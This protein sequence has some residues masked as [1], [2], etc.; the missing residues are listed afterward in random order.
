[1]SETKT[2]KL[3]KKHYCRPALFI[4]ET[5][6]LEFTKGKLPNHFHIERYIWVDTL[7]PEYRIAIPEDVSQWEDDETSWRDLKGG[8]Q[9][10]FV[11]YIPTGKTIYDN[12]LPPSKAIVF[13]YE[14]DVYTKSLA[15][16]A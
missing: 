16:K 12:T 13:E 6:Y 7:L 8:I 9:T 3:I 2:A 5:E 14:L 15:R 4:P 1:M 11:T 10:R